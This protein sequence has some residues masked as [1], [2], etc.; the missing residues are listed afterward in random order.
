MHTPRGESKSIDPE[1]TL[2]D[3]DGYNRVILEA[4]LAL[5]DLPLAL[6]NGKATTNASTPGISGKEQ[7]G[8]SRKR[9]RRCVGG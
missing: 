7:K 6:I 9:R 2:W 3:A 4:C 1:M 8:R 5:K